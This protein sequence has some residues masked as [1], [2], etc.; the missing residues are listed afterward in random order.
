MRYFI[1]EDDIERE[2]IDVC[3]NELGY[4]NHFNC[5]V[6][7]HLHRSSERGVLNLDVLRREV[8]RINASATDRLQG[9][10]DADVNTAISA[11]NDI[12]LHSDP[13]SLNATILTRIMSGFKM[14]VLQSNGKREPRTVQFI[15]W[16]NPTS[17]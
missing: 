13:A 7:D 1:K 12:D 17:N 9:F 2:L 6:T 3:L 11:L 14:P 5:Y 8:K 10:D 4:N 15:D 16:E